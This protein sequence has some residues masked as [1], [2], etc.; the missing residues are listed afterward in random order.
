MNDQQINFT[1][2]FAMPTHE[3]WVAEVEKALKGAPFDKRMLTKTHEGITLRPIYTRQD[4]PAAGDPSGFPGA[5]PFTRSER[6]SGNRVDDWDS[7]GAYAVPDPAAGNDVILRDLERGVKSIELVFDAASRAGLD[8]DAAGAAALAGVDGVMLYS[9]DDLDRLLTGVYLD[10]APIHLDAGAQFL[11]AAALLASLWQRRNIKPDAAK[12]AFDADPLAALA[13]GGK[14][15]VAIDAALAQMADLAR[16]TAA[17]YPNVTAVGVD[18]SP[19]H[20]AGATETQDLAASMAT[21]VA[22]LKAM[23]AAGL[24]IDTA[25]RQILFTYSVPCDQFLGICKLRAAR[26]MWAQIAESCGASEPAR[27]MRLHA[28]TS[29]R[30]MSKR[31]PWVNILRT[32]VGCFAA[33]VGGADSVTVRPFDAAIG[34]SEELGR[35]ISRNTHVVLAEESNLAKVTD[36]GG[37]SWYIETRTEEIA[38]AAWAEFQAIEQAG[39]M[40]AVLKD[41]SF[42]ARIAASYKQREAAIAKRRDPVTGVSEFPNILETPI[43]HEA[44]DLLG[45]ARAAAERLAA[46]RRGHAA[47]SGAVQALTTAAAGALTEAAIAAVTAGATLGAIAAALAGGGEQIAPLPKH[48]YGEQFEALRDASDAYLAKTGARPQIFSANLGTVAQHTGRATFT[49]NFFEAAGI[50][51][52]GNTGFADAQSCVDAFKKSGARVA[53]LCSS[54]AVYEQLAASTAQAL[55]AAGCEYLF[56]AGAPGDKKDA[57]NAAGIDD[58]IFMGGDVL[59]TTR[60][61]LARLGVI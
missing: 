11:P 16:Y 8:G 21:A 38:K 18:T 47:A 3:Q 51:V 56:L 53:I 36:A 42:A 5:M 35:R 43:A 20:D 2:G 33:A 6:A 61:T 60:T 54:D 50:Q 40:V 57:Y 37:G 19:Y 15:P 46:Y 27:A 25:C 29:S 13:E 45:L 12:G 24:D 7:R 17:H 39:G 41:G 22:Y 44:A 32:T 1:E 9:A 30:M 31:D 55:K 28:V 23:T 14:L 59:Q 10:L 26:K 34:L 49:K 48:R 4:W 58:F 52:P